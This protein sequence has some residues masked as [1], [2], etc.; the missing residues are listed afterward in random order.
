VP[1]TTNNLLIP[2]PVSGTHLGFST[3]RMEPCWMAMGQAAGVAASLSISGGMPVQS[4]SITLLQ[5]ALLNQNA[6]LIYYED[7]T[8]EHPNYIALQYFGLRGV[9]PEWEAGL[10]DP[11]SEESAQSWWNRSGLSERISYEPG[12]TTRG[13]YLQRLYD[14]VTAQPE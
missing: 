9:I 8:P 13:D 7:T 14:A 12:L 1:I 5:D 4:I 11:V 3:L 6:V 2:V 10:D